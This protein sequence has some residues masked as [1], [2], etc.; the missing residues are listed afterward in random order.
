[1]STR[2]FFVLRSARTL[3]LDSAPSGVGRNPDVDYYGEKRRRDTHESKTDKG[4]LLFKKTKGSESK[5]AYLGHLLMENRHGLVDNAQV[6][7]ATGTAERD[8]AVDMVQAL[9]GTHRVTLG[10]DKAYDTRGCVDALR[11]ANVTP[12]VGQTRATVRRRSMDVPPAIPAMSLASDSATALRS[13][14]AGPRP[15]VACARAGLSA[16]RSWTFNSS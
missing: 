13:A 16:A 5:L 6:T 4:A 1:V 11:C 8:A 12:H 9:S 14:S 15:S 3:Q 2:T 7:Q 10:A